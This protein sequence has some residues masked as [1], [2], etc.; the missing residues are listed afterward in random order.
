MVGHGP[1]GCA[2]LDAAVSLDYETFGFERAIYPD[3][4]LGEPAEA[5]STV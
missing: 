2:G 1:D 5:A 3:L 4:K